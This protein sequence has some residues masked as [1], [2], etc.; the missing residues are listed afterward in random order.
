MIDNRTLRVPDV[1]DS[2]LRK[3]LPEDLEARGATFIERTAPK[4]R[5]DG[6]AHQRRVRANRIARS[7]DLEGSESL[8]NANRPRSARGDNEQPGRNGAAKSGL[9]R[10]LAESS[11]GYQTTEQ[12][13][14]CVRHG[15]RYRLVPAAGTS[16]T[17]GQC[18]HRDRKNHETQAVFRCRQSVLGDQTGRRTRRGGA[19]EGRKG[20]GGYGRPTLNR[21]RNA[22]AEAR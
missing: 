2:R 11:P 15:T 21:T 13:A 6:R 14:A 8:Q 4:P 9:N 3:A 18:G 17:C 7:N 16:I 5:K 10:S 1:G 20:Q 19:Q 12:M 22:Y